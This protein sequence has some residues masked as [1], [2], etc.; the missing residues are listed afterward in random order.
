MSKDGSDGI[1][2]RGAAYLRPNKTNKGGVRGGR[3]DRSG[4][5]ADTVPP[6]YSKAPKGLHI[7]NERV[8]RMTRRL[9]HAFPWLTQADHALVRCFCM[10]TILSEESFAKIDA[11]GLTRKSGGPHLLLAD[12]RSLVR[13]QAFIASRLGLS[14]VDRS[15][16]LSNGASTALV[17]D[18]L[19][20][21]GVNRIL[22]QRGGGDQLVVASAEP[23]PV[24]DDGDNRD[25]VDDKSAPSD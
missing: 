7:R 10:V 14:P 9:L 22:K 15:Q 19:D 13:T 17:L 6:I 11:E 21:R 25:A 5:V 4:R 24:L 20:L 12:F 23:K 3:G 16:M 18:S 1:T 2:V 8:A